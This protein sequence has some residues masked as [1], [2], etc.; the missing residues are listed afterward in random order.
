MAISLAAH[1][2]IQAIQLLSVDMPIRSLVGRKK[3]G[4]F[5]ILIKHF[6]SGLVQKCLVVHL[7]V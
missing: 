3:Y 5:Q 1:W 7:L 4:R 2:V 6:L